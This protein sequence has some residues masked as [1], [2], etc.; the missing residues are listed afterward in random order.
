MSSLNSNS[1]PWLQ[2]YETNVPHM[3]DHSVYSSIASAMEHSFEKYANRPAFH[4]MGTSISYGELQTLSA[5]FGD[6]LTHTLGLKKGDRVALMMPNVLQYPIALFGVIRSGLT[7]VNVNPLY[8]PRE[9]EHQL[10]DS[11][12]KVIVLFENAC[13]TLEKVIAKTK[14]K[15]VIRTGIGDMLRFPKSLLVNT[16]IKYVKKMVPTWNIP[17][18]VTFKEALAAG[19]SGRF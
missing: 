7:V 11:G 6:Y 3:I 9:L 10:N 12:A 8:T 1:T 16:V 19:Q 4:C 17:N 13:H 2:S 5:Q 18:T 14:V 15:H